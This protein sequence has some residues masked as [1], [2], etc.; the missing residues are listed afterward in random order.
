MRKFI[1]RNF[2]E[3]SRFCRTASRDA[4][5]DSF[6]K[7]R[8]DICGQEVV[9]NGSTML[10]KLGRNILVCSHCVQQNPFLRA[11]RPIKRVKNDVSS[12]KKTT[13]KDDNE[14]VSLYT[15]QKWWKDR[16]PLDI[17]YDDNG[18]KKELFIHWYYLDR[19]DDNLNELEVFHTNMLYR[20][21]VMERFDTIYLN[22]AVDGNHHITSSMQ[23]V[24]DVLSSG[25]AKVMFK[26]IK[27]TKSGENKT[28]REFI[29][30]CLVKKEKYVCYTHFKGVTSIHRNNLTSLIDILYWCFIMY[31]SIFSK[32][33]YASV[34]NG[35]SAA[36]ILLELDHNSHSIEFFKKSYYHNSG[37]FCFF[38][39]K[40]VE[41]IF[42]KTKLSKKDFL[43]KFNGYYSVEKFL[44]SFFDKNE[45][46]HKLDVKLSPSSMYKLFNLNICKETMDEF[47]IF[48]RY[49]IVSMT[50][51]S[52]RI[53]NVEHVLR[54][55][56]DQTIKPDKVVINLSSEEFPEKEKNLP[57]DLIDLINANEVLE[58][59][60]CDKNTG[61]FKKIIPTLQKYKNHNYYLISIDDDNLYSQNYIEFL[62]KEISTKDVKV[63]CAA[64]MEISG[65]L[66][67]YDSSIFDEKL[68]TKLTDT[69]IKLN[70]SDL[71]YLKYIKN[72]KKLKC[73][74]NSSNTDNLFSSYNPIYPNSGT[75]SRQ[76]DPNRLLAV[77]EELSK[78]DFN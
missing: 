53:P 48:C 65:G 69:L 75:K 5:I 22:I 24:I 57:K 58:I 40:R 72:Y 60:W 17:H 49:L 45:V 16:K 28:N 12:T 43:E 38:N 18:T 1:L 42:E 50:S 30:S 70:V 6:F 27:N 20:Y 21:N 78:I 62:L 67:I 36:G 11:T 63:Y 74:H 3:F 59:N 15:N 19:K 37:S 51:W 44:L 52:K 31:S 41:D 2:E 8:C 26:L 61:T 71:Y 55:I 35:L 7:Y 66:M 64:N 77:R 68:W 47:K 34:K 76:Y 39:S 4:V 29:K 13:T 23:E 56:L 9:E 14:L 25:R 46:Y 54:S 32:D 33:A 10:T 73:E